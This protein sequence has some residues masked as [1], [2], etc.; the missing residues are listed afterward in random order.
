M[1]DTNHARTYSC[2][3]TTPRA[4]AQEVQDQLAQCKLPPLAV[5]RDPKTP[6]GSTASFEHLALRRMT[7][8][9]SWTRQMPR[10]GSGPVVWEVVEPQVRTWA[11]RFIGLLDRLLAGERF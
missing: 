10:T 1:S 4:C 7:K 11:C 5:T 8:R 2:N 3:L 9:R 6:Q